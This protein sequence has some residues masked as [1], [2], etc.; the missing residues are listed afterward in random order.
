MIFVAVGTQKFPLNRLLVKL[1]ELVEKGVI[2][3]EIFAQ[4]G[5]CTY[6]PKNFAS[7]SFMTKE[8]FEQRIAEC[9][10]VITHS[11]VNTIVSALKAHKKVIVFPRLLKYNEHVDDHQCQI[12]LAFS[13]KE[14]VLFCKDENDLENQLERVRDFQP[15][16]YQSQRKNV[17]QIIEGYLQEQEKSGKNKTGKLRTKT[18]LMCGSDPE[19]VGGGMISV[20]KQYL[21][22]DG[23][24]GYRILYVPTHIECGK[25]KQSLYY[26]N[27]FRKVAQ[28]LLTKKADL[29]HLHIAERGSFFRKAFLVRLC[30]L[31]RTK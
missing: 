25:V 14:Y 9:D 13:K 5:S 10:F 6:V 15:K 11:G 2:T 18:V 28:I 26:L 23:E 22:R 17:I 3:E 29:V 31:C 27:A 4:T 8:E 19:R 7:A 30:R 12:A 24:D 1:D 20:I 21:S 16:E